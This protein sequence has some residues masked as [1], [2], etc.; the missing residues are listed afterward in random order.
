MINIYI[1]DSWESC[2]W[3]HWSVRPGRRQTHASSLRVTSGSFSQVYR[4][5]RSYN[6]FVSRLWFEAQMYIQ[7]R[8]RSRARI[9]GG[10]KKKTSTGR[11]FEFS[12]HSPSECD[13][14]DLEEGSH[15]WASIWDPWLTVYV[16]ACPKIGIT[17]AWQM[18]FSNTWYEF[19]SLFSPPP[20]LAWLKGQLTT[21][22]Q[23]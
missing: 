2:G 22:P 12:K 14:A 9:R 5:T 10:K 15:I 4:D 20:Q 18:T 8:K 13:S 23:K 11:P 21:K 6:A 7:T 1:C 16:E 3:R 17:V 19:P